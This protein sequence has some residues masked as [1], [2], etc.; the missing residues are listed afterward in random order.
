[1]NCYIFKNDPMFVCSCLS[2]SVFI[3][4]NHLDLHNSGQGKHMSKILK[5]TDCFK[6][7]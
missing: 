4:N 6:S 1:M 5:N 3:C 7:Y 2:P